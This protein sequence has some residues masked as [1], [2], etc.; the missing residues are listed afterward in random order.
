MLTMQETKDLLR[1]SYRTIHRLVSNN[2]I[3]SVKVGRVIRIPQSALKKFILNDTSGGSGNDY[4][5]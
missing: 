1:V 4:Q 2:T 5:Q 3:P